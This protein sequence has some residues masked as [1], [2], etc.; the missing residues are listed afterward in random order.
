MEIKL[1]ETLKKLRRERGNTQEELANHLNISMQA[2]SKWERGDGLP[3]ISLL[4]S[5]ALYYNI[6]LDSLFGMDEKAIDAKIAEYEKR[7]DDL[8]LDGDSRARLTLWR[9]AAKEFPNN[10]KVLKRL[11]YR[12][13]RFDKSEFEERR[14]LGQRLLAESSDIELRQSVIRVLCFDCVD[15]GDLE[16]AKQYAEMAPSFL[17]CREL[18]YNGCLK[19]EE[20]VE[21]NQDVIC[22]LTD[23]I[24]DCIKNYVQCR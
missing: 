17:T 3:D 19:G 13:N 9:E 4:P 1:A 24:Y 11:F 12:F 7:D 23:S 2:I 10:H 18:I 5:I 22:R 14:K 20:C 15:A 21:Y 8:I 6:S 16:T